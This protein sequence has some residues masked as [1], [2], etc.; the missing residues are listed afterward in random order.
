[1]IVICYELDSI[2]CIIP[3]FLNQ[4]LRIMEPERVY[5]FI[6]LRVYFFLIVLFFPPLPAGG[7]D[8]RCSEIAS[9]IGL[10]SRSLRMLSG[11]F[12][13]NEVESASSSVFDIACSGIDGLIC[14]TKV[15]GGAEDAGA[16]AGAEDAGAEDASAGGA[17]IRS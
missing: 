5:Y 7:K 6:H 8:L 12:K 14:W 9:I 17:T 4:F 11:S 15:G 10:R 3:L 2:C 13:F 1:M 16:D